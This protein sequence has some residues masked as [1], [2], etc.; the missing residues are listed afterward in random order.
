MTTAYQVIKDMT[1]MD[2]TA[3]SSSDV[4]STATIDLGKYVHLMGMRTSTEDVLRYPKLDWQLFSCK[5]K[6][7]RGWGEQDCKKKWQAL[8]SD[9][10]NIC[11]H[12][13]Q[14]DPVFGSARIYCPPDLIGEEAGE[15]RVA[16]FEE[17]TFEQATKEK[18]LGDAEIA[19]WK[20][21]TKTGFAPMA[22]LNV[23]NSRVFTPMALGSIASGS[24]LNEQARLMMAR[25]CSTARE[26]EPMEEAAKKF[27]PG[28]EVPV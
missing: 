2:N 7:A 13:G 23:D 8:V 1:L 10:R 24:D 22:Q 3:G 19:A 27:Q 14:H 16:T 6:A 21:A 15:K 20:D 28:D 4:K 11:D 12:K 5:L 25:A 26:Y 17:R 9:E 18:V